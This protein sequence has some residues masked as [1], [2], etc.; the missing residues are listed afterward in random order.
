MPEWASRLSCSRC[1][2]RRVDFVVTPR[3]TGGL[4]SGAPDRKW[5]VAAAELEPDGRYARDIAAYDAGRI[6]ELKRIKRETSISAP[7]MSRALH[8]LSRKGLVWRHAA[9]LNL[10]GW[11]GRRTRHVSLIDAGIAAVAELSYADRTSAR[12]TR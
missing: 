12:R 11:D 3:S 6:V 9:D 1:G 10:A 2:S 5:L 8:S 4:D 7:A